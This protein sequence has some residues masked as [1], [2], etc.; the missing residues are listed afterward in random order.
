MAETLR[1]LVVVLSLDPSAA[2]RM[3]Y[4]GLYPSDAGCEI[5]AGLFAEGINKVTE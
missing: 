4:D 5:P 3:T 2:N 1:E